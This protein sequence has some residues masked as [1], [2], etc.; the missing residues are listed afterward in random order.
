[1]TNLQEDAEG[2]R[3]SCSNE[4]GTDSTCYAKKPNNGDFII[5]KTLIS[6][7]KYIT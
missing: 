1:V 5:K 2:W 6:E 7:T 3:W 4:A